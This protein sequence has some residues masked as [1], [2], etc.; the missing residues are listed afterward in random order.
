MTWGPPYTR[1]PKWDPKPLPAIK[2]GRFK[3]SASINQTRQVWV[4]TW[5]PADLRPVLTYHLLQWSLD[6]ARFLASEQ[7]PGKGI[8]ETKALNPKPQTNRRLYGSRD[9]IPGFRVSGSGLSESL[10]ESQAP[11]AGVK[12]GYLIF[13]VKSENPKRL[14]S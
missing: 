2:L 10:H 13:T 3:V 1:D 5:V 11:Q 8:V 7:G 12:R 9:P 14:D 4:C 6:P